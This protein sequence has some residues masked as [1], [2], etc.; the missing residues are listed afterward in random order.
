MAGLIVSRAVTKS[1]TGTWGLG[2]GAWDVGR[3][4]AGTRGRGDAGTRGR[5]DAGTR[6]RGDAGTWG[7]G[8]SGNWGVGTGGRD[9]HTSRD[10]CAEFLKYNFRRSSDM[11]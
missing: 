1:G 6:G 8:H 11:G 9:K 5:G 2:R 4:D 3:G 7:C 10:F